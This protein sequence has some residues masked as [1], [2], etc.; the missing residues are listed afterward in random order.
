M[1]ETLQ[2]SFRSRVSVREVDK[3]GMVLELKKSRLHLLNLSPGLKA[4]LKLL[5][6]PAASESGLYDVTEQIDRDFMSCCRLIYYLLV[7]RRSGFLEDSLKSGN[8]LLATIQYLDDGRFLPVSVPT[9]C[10]LVLSRFAY[11]RKWGDEAVL[12][13]PLCQTRIVVREAECFNAIFC[14]IS[15]RTSQELFAGKRALL[16]GQMRT[17]V[18]L[19]YALSFVREAEEEQESQSSCWEFHDLL[20]HT[21]ARVW[22]YSHIG[23]TFRFGLK[24]RPAPALKPP[25]STQSVKLYRPDIESLVLNDRPFTEVLERRKSLRGD[26]GRAISADQVGE[27]LYRVARVR[28]SKFV[29]GSEGEVCLTER[30]YPNAGACYELEIYLLIERCD[31][32]PRGLYHYRPDS[33]ELSGIR[34]GATYL[35]QIVQDVKTAAPGSAPQVILILSARFARVFWQYEGIGYSLILK[36]VGVLFQTMYLVATAMGLMPCAVG[37]GNSGLFARVTGIDGLAEASV[38]EFILNGS[39]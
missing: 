39:T 4:A 31:G 1:I 29:A 36:N 9:H 13:S 10:Q 27:F 38:G 26:S 12:E 33:H 24:S 30:P 35:E 32:I 17:F 8:R 22:R 20:L 19:L 28:S 25:M 5:V 16:R 23:S 14:L 21:K 34:A 2:V 7:L 3:D 37:A 6:S 15:P 18:D 11:L